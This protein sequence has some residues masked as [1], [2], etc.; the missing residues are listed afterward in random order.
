MPDDSEE[1]LNL[2]FLEALTL[3]DLTESCAAKQ[4]NRKNRR[5]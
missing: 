5:E 4:Q 1:K 3:N 2:Y